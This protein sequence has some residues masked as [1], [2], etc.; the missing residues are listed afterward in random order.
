MTDSLSS[1][2]DF[3]PP[4]VEA[5][6]KKLY[7]CHRTCQPLPSAVELYQA[8]CAAHDKLVDLAES[9]LETPALNRTPVPYCVHGGYPHMVGPD[10]ICIGCSFE[11]WPKQAVT[12]PRGGS[13]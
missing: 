7:E 1:K 12:V 5:M 8:F 6:R 11:F 3:I 13:L 2:Q 10:G 4:E 9:A